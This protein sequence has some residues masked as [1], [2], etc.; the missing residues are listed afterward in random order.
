M[1]REHSFSK[2][3][4]EKRTL[5][6]RLSGRQPKEN[7]VAEIN[8]RLAAVHRVT[9]ADSS[10]VAEALERCGASSIE[11]LKSEL[12]GLY[13]EYLGH[14]L[15]DRRLDEAEIENLRHLKRILQLSDAAVSEA[16]V[17]A[18][19]RAYRSA[20]DGVVADGVLDD[21]EKDFL[22]QT[23]A[24]LEL[25]NSIAAKIYD[26]AAKH[27]YFDRLNE[28]V[29]D[30][31][32]APEEEEELEAIAQS[33]GVTPD[34]SEDT[35]AALNRYRLFWM[36]ENGELPGIEVGINLQKTERCYWTTEVDWFELRRVTTRV[37]YSGPTVRVKIVKGV[38]WR[39]GSFKP[40]S[41]AEDVMQ[42]IDSGPLY[43]TSK[44]L[45]FIGAKQNKTIRLSSVL[46]FQP[47]SNGLEIQKSTG[48]S[49]FLAFDQNVDI[50]SRLMARALSDL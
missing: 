20:V 12:L 50:V 41:V 33:L 16:H 26:D 42:H 34:H 9:E 17:E 2:R 48:K 1:A 45:I 37:G 25:D 3:A 30:D 23:R 32:L 15:S 4:L 11:T 29:A 35:Q 10:D 6:Q 13:R 21:D 5:L 8:N 49:P 36:I 24:A 7:A 28:V 22:E 19:S 43:L 27:R 40:H 38:Y 39:A 14:C 18:A 31:K 44:R 47:Y 46:D